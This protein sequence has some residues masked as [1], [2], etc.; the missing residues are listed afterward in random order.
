VHQH[1][2]QLVRQRGDLID[3]RH[4]GTHRYLPSEPPQVWCRFL[5]S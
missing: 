2:R 3:L 5:L 1:M 4:I